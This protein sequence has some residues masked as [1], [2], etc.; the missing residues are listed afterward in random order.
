MD[1][2]KYEVPLESLRWRCDQK[3]F[4]FQT[5]DEVE[6]L[7]EFI[8]QDRAI[9]AIEFGLSLNRPGYNIFVTGLTGTGKMSVIKAYLEKVVAEKTGVDMPERLHDWCY[10]YNF[11]APDR[12]RVVRLPKGQGKVFRGEVEQLLTSLRREVNKV[13]SGEEY[14]NQR[15]EVVEKGQALREKLFREV[16]REAKARGF[17]IRPSPL[18]IAAIPLDREGKPLTRE[19][20]N[21]L[22]EADR[23]A[24][25]ER[26]GE[27]MRRVQEAVEQAKAIEKEALEQ[28]AS[29]D[30]KVAEFTIKPLFA[31][32]LEKYASVDDVGLYLEGAESFVMEHIDVLRGTE[33]EKAAVPPGAEALVSRDRNLGLAFQVNVFVDNS[34]TKGLPIVVE[35]NPTFG[36]MFGKLERRAFMGA[37]FSD[38]TM[39][40]PGALSLANGGYLIVSVRDVLLSPGVWE[41]LKRAIKTKESR[42][43]DPWE[44]YGFVVPVGLRPEPVP[45]DVKV[46]IVGDDLLYHL[47]S[48]SDEDFWEM[49]KV[50]A[51]FDYEI[52]RTQDN[53]NAYASLV[54]DICKKEG[55][56]HFDASGVSKVIEYGARLVADQNKLSSRFGLVRDIL[57]EADQWSRGR[58][59]TLVDEEDVRQALEAKV[60]RSD[61][62][63]Q[64]LRE[65]MRDGTIMV[66]TEGAVVGQVNGLSV[67]DLGD[68]SFGRPSRIT[69]RTFVGRRGVINVERES[70][71]SGRIHD[72]GV[73]ILAGYLGWKYA[74]DRPLSLSAS[75][76]FEQSYEGVE[77]DSASSAELY[78]ILS[79]LSDV[80]LKQGMAVTGSVNQKGELQPIGGVNQKIEG[81]FDLCRAKGLTGD[82]GV[83]IPRQNVRN[84]MLRE[85]VVEAVGQGKFHIWAIGTI[86][87]GMEMLTGTSMG[88]RAEDGRYPEGSINARVEGRLRQFV[89]RLKEHP[90]EPAA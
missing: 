14:E 25:D 9:K 53:M 44:F 7:Q 34:E 19:D 3:S 61:L 16:D 40:K 24:L 43:E 87:E 55:M 42:L 33:T 79:S 47:L 69:A 27:V 52:D 38:H 37:Y 35:T 80:P 84:L 15:K 46:I 59:K 21:A 18:G 13:F 1:L 29:L 56:C 30:Q 11:P 10:V 76:C 5:T 41:G 50:K 54:S 57:I 82:Q 83:V 75:L 23:Q 77:G 49:F 17:D 6:P 28:V 60:Y 86:E 85:D 4:C 45:I 48:I 88:E 64:R 74:Q 78:A 39:L 8:G 66:D 26:Q 65:H 71:L 12:P 22:S 36:N 32:L 2:M 31:N 72:K 90:P 68:I 81:F 73:L 62:L 67:Y 89:E 70:Q 58:G 51:D 63:A 20:Y